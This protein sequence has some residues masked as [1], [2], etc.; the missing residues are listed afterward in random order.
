MDEALCVATQELCDKRTAEAAAEAEKMQ[1]IQSRK[2]FHYNKCY[3]WVKAV[4]RVEQ[5]WL[6]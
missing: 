1:T 3:S 5:A 2:V 6:V 4:L